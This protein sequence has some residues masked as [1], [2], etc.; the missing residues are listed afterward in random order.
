MGNNT[1]SGP[2]PIKLCYN[3]QSQHDRFSLRVVGQDFMSHLATPT[4]L[5]V[6][7]EWKS[8]VEHVV[9]IHPNRS[10][11]QLRGDSMCF[12]NVARPNSGSQ[13]ILTLICPGN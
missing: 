1:G 4:G 12:R 3:L 11:F 5:L 7:A 2:V 9:A 13:A 8:G 10:R 6:A